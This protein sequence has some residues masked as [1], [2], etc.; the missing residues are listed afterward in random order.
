MHEKEFEII[1]D[2]VSEFF[3]VIDQMGHSGLGVA[4]LVKAA[5]M[6]MFAADI[7]KGRDIN[8][9]EAASHLADGIRALYQDLLEA[10]D[11][12]AAVIAKAKGGKK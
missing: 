7:E 10:H 6:I 5:G 2:M 11:P 8:P 3:D 4:A 12:A 9:D 1:D